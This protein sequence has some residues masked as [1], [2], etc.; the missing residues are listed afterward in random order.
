MIAPFLSLCILLGTRITNG[1]PCQ[2]FDL[3]DSSNLTFTGSPA[4]S[5]VSLAPLSQLLAQIQVC[6]QGFSVQLS[7]QE[8][9]VRFQ[10]DD[11]SVLISAAKPDIQKVLARTVIPGS[12]EPLKQTAC[13]NGID[14]DGDGVTDFG[15]DAGCSS[16]E[17][18]DETGEGERA[19]G[20]PISMEWDSKGFLTSLTY[21]GHAI[22]DQKNTPDDLLV[23]PHSDAGSM[24]TDWQFFTYEDIPW[25]PNR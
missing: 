3:N 21:N 9:V 24:T 8:V 12:F 19:E 4:K 17:D 15:I 20:E 25:H 11:N 22:V 14:D 2:T 1:L 10:T 13:S 5:L 18:D 16:W 6:G 23:Y 7:D